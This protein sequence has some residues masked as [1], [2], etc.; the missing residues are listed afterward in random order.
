MS[1]N[2]ICIKK[3]VEVILENRYRSI[4]DN[5]SVLIAKLISKVCTFQYSLLNNQLRFTFDSLLS[6]HDDEQ[7]TLIAAFHLMST[8]FL[9]HFI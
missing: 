1:N 8:L 5:G 4:Y 6:M 3:L 9:L 2:S 7:I